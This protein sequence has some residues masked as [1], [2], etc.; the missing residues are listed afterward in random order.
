MFQT[1]GGHASYGVLGACCQGTTIELTVPI[2]TQIACC[3]FTI[4]S[5][6]CWLSCDKME[7]PGSLLGMKGAYLS[8]L[9]LAGA[10]GASGGGKR[11]LPVG[12]VPQHTLLHLS[13]SSGAERLRPSS[14]V[15]LQQ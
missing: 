12:G 9:A 15:V 10:G 6:G 11:G 4:M 2:L 3:K 1:T 14:L 8:L 7:A 5:G 13:P